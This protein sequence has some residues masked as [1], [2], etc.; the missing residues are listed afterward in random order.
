MLKGCYLMLFASVVNRFWSYVYKDGPIICPDLGPC[1]IW[2][3]DRYLSGYGRI[4]YNNRPGYAHRLSW[5]IHNETCKDLDVLHK[6]DNPPCV[7]P[8]HLFLGTQKDNAQDMVIKK[9]S[10]I[11]ER[12]PRAVVS[13]KIVVELKR[14]WQTG[15]YSLKELM[16]LSGLSGSGLRGILSGKR[17]KHVG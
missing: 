8:E 11:G 15:R 6:C 16:E 2:I 3:G 4:G 13:E 14:M 12:N 9:R 1:W 5:I 10:L 17:W 7:N